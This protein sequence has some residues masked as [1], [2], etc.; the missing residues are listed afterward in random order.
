MMHEMP[1]SL[2]ALKFVMP[3]LYAVIALQFANGGRLASS[4]TRRIGCFSMVAIFVFCG[5]SGYLA[6]ALQLGE[7]VSV[8]SHIL[9]SLA[10][11]VFIVTNQAR[12]IIRD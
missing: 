9:L 6:P 8:W 1:D 10:C 12:T 5:F 2:L 3:A 11:L 7:K 4:W